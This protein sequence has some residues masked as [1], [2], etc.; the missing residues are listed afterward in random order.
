VAVE[1]V[2]CREVVELVTDF[3]EGNLA[4]DRRDVFERHIA[5]CAWCETYLYQM[6]HTLIVLGGLREDDVPAPLVDSLALAFRAERQGAT[7]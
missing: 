3:L 7:G 6:R 2:S 5:M 1:D 4:I